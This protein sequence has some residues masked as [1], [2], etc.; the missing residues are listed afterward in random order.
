MKTNQNDLYLTLGFAFLAFILRLPFR[1]H[2]LYHWDSVNFALSLEKFDVRIHQPHPPGYI[3]Y[4]YLGRLV[5]FLVQDANSSLVWISLVSGALG[6]VAIYW[7]GRLMF[8]RKIGIVAALF[9]LTSPMHWFYSEVALSYELEF[10][11]VILIAGLAYLQIEGNGQ[12]W[13]WL[14]LLIGVAGGVRQNDIVFMLPLWL[15]SLYFIGWRQRIWS[16]LITGLVILAWLVPMAA[17][18]GGLAG[19]LGAL[20]SGSSDVFGESAI[21]SPV[22]LALNGVRMLAFAGYALISGNLL[23]V[24]GA[25]LLLKNWRNLLHDRRAWVLALWSL[26]AMIFYLF[27]HLRQHGHIFTFLP[28]LLLIAAFLAVRLGEGLANRL[29]VRSATVLLSAAVALVSV[30]FFLFA[31]ARLLG[32]ERLIMQT[33]SRNTISFRDASLNERIRLVQAHFDPKS[34]VVMGGGWDFR[35]PDYY[36]RDY[37]MTDLSYRL[38]GRPI[39][40]PDYVNTVV[41]IAPVY[42]NEILA[43]LPHKSLPLAG[44]EIL[45]YVAWDTGVHAQLDRTHFELV[46]P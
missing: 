30:V 2:Y 25:W 39:R 29:R 8:N 37:Q 38:S 18:S 28:A 46:G 17:L 31:P 45:E 20:S 24:Y 14:A 32:S 3:L 19:Y 36:L 23:F 33:P 34:T 44:G 35:I 11:I 21:F 15:F 43:G 41:F 4:S 5:N 1:S 40:L 7:L 27:I 6:I 9:T 10:F 42:S 22:Q 26:P 16:I 13:P 12:V